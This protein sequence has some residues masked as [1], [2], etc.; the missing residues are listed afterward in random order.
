MKLE[1][2][3]HCR[4]V[5][6]SVESHEPYPFNQCYCTVCRKTNGSG[7]YAINLAADFRTLEVHG[8]EH[9]TLYRATIQEPGDTEPRKSAFERSFCSI[10]GSGLW[11]WHPKW[12]NLLHPFASVVDTVL[13]TPPQRQHMMLDF[14]AP[15]VDTHA[16]PD[17]EHF[18]RYPELS[19]ADWHEQ[20]GLRA[21][22][23]ESA[24]G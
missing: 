3:C 7:G 21:S 18:A 13:P 1:G 10:C 11:G 24:P 22:D 12:P 5:R 16:G 15:W 2:S 14:K 23:Q 8:R 20:H 6:F 4:A 9:I 17:D 19:L